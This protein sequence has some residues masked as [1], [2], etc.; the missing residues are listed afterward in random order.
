MEGLVYAMMDTTM[1]ELLYV[2]H[3][4]FHV[5]HAPGQDQ[6]NVFSVKH[7]ILGLPSLMLVLALLVTLKIMFKRVLNAIIHAMSAMLV[8]LKHA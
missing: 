2:N 7:Q 1:M 5:K 8:V 3:V 4:I 6:T